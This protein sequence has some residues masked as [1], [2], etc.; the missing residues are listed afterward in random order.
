MTVRAALFGVL[1]CSSCAAQKAPTLRPR[2]A[3]DSRTAWNVLCR[4][5]AHNAPCA[6]LLSA[7]LRVLVDGKPLE[8]AAVSVEQSTPAVE[9]V[10]DALNTPL[11]DLQRSRLALQDALR[12]LPST[13]PYAVSLFV[14]ADSKPQS[15]R[16]ALDGWELLKS[17]LYVAR[18]GPSQ[19]TAELLAGLD[20]YQPTLR[21]IDT[22]Q[23]APG[24]M[25]RVHL[26]LQALG[27][28]AGAVKNSK[29]PNLML[30]IGPGWPSVH[31]ND[32]GLR[33]QVFDSV[34]YFDGALRQSR[35]TLS[36]LDPTGAGT[37]RPAENS[38]GALTAALSHAP[39]AATHG[40]EG[41]AD[42]FRAYLTPPRSA[43]EA[44]PNDL[45]LPVLAGHSGGTVQVMSNDTAGGILRFLAD[46]P[47]LWTV[48]TPSAV[49]AGPYHMLQFEPLRTGIMLRSATGF[50]A[51]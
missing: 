42:L 32:S 31:L 38:E 24:A 11:T 9:I 1:L 18:I 22:A 30:W 13:L 19:S 27:F 41:G 36:A 34:L 44:Q 35:V 16:D 28:L 8:A 40:G 47:A 45:L 23:A 2:T 51:R 25:E 37:S 14:V 12:R 15:S 49:G 33:G 48:R 7:D 26:S 6:T 20:R 46:V 10:L 50:Y 39:H 43:R 5:T 29:E 17:E 3:D 21:R 4:E